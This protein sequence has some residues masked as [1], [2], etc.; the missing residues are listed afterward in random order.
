MKILGTGLSGLVGSRITELLKDKYEFDNLSLETGVDITNRASVIDKI[1]EKNPDVILHMA[2]K[3]DVDGCEEDKEEDIKILRYKDIEKQE[4]AWRLKRTAWAVNVAGTKNVVDA[5][6]KIGKKLIY[7]STDFVFSGENPPSGGY[8]EEDNPM[9]INWY[10]RTKYEGELIVQNSTLPWTIVRLAYPYRAS[11]SKNDFVRTLIHLME[12]N[13][14]LSM[15]EDH[16][17]TPTFIDDI[18]YALDIVLENSSIGIYH[19][20]GSQF[21]NPY[22]AAA[23]VA[24][25]FSLP[26]TLITKTTR[27]EFFKNRAPRPFHLALKNDK[28]K[29][30]GAAMRTFEEGL[31]EIRKQLVASR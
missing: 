6:G 4:E 20:V 10:G 1:V 7:V 31:K 13:K 22:D 24:E 30:L 25:I 12:A 21:L 3:T 17:M 18:V 2:A 28:I 14:S 15:V 5:C 27:Y 29:K 8:K 16:I 19:L 26:K 23:L 9:P 11:Y